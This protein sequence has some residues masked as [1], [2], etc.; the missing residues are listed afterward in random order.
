[1]IIAWKSQTGANYTQFL[2]QTG[3]ITDEQEASATQVR[4]TVARTSPGM[5]EAGATRSRPLGED[6]A[7]IANDPRDGRS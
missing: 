7:T 3:N 5:G 6:A 1:M 4:P 2:Q